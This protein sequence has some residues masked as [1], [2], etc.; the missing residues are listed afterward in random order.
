MLSRRQIDWICSR[1]TAG[2]QIEVDVDMEATK[3]RGAAYTKGM[4]TAMVCARVEVHGLGKK[5]TSELEE[6]MLRCYKSQL[7]KRNVTDSNSRTGRDLWNKSGEC[8]RELL[9]V[10]QPA[11]NKVMGGRDAPPSGKQLAEMLELFHERLWHLAQEAKIKASDKAAARLKDLH[12][13]A[14]VCRVEDDAVKYWGRVVADG[15]N[16]TSATIKPY[17]GS[18]F[19]VSQDDVAAMVAAA[20]ER[21]DCS[22]YPV[23]AAPKKRGRCEDK[24]VKGWS[25]DL[26]E[27]WQI[28]G[29]LGDEG[30]NQLI[31]GSNLSSG[32][33]PR[34]P[35]ARRAPTSNRVTQRAKDKAALVGDQAEKQS[36]KEARQEEAARIAKKTNY[37]EQRKQQ[38]DHLKLEFEFAPDDA[39]KAE[40]RE[41]LMDFMRNAPL[42]PPK[43]KTASPEGAKE[44]AR[45]PEPEIA[46][47][48]ADPAAAAPPPCDST[49][50]M[51]PR[52]K[53]SR[54]LEE[55]AGGAR[56]NKTARGIGKFLEDLSPAATGEATPP[57]EAA[58]FGSDGSDLE[59]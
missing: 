23:E 45:A 2:E 52:P 9:N 33:A 42:S 29:P 7:D 26:F 53:K 8:F 15:T 46:P 17:D 38:I 13:G 58:D 59:N 57:K 55:G 5:S 56:A 18:K 43:A 4:K 24:F 30:K 3:G 28:F 21:I 54:P 32:P 37:L 6:C 34:D 47:P 31:F 40:A 22:P 12:V 10:L 49:P 19:K 41:A 11:W 25:H 35:A 16:K 48:V 20:E 44:A 27:A 50:E 51:P 14:L 1:A 39:S 36:K